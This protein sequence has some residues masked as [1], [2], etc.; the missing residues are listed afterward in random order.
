MK[1]LR[2]Y[3]LGY[4]LSAILSVT[5][6][7]AIFAV[8]WKI[9]PT[10]S[11]SADPLHAFWNYIWSDDFGPILGIQFKPVF[12]II[13]ASATL[14][15][16]TAFLAFSRQWF[17]LPGKTLKLECPFCR[18]RWQASSDRGQVVCPHCHHLVHPKMAK[19]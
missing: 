10:L 11:S 9:W 7:A 8:I 1:T 14:V 5:S 18:K 6:L 16:A 13:L 15:L 17:F 2:K 4:A 3:K 12:L 19:A